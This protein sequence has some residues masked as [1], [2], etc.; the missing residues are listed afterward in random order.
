MYTVIQDNLQLFIVQKY[1][2]FRGFHTIEISGFSPPDLT[3]HNSQ[4][5]LPNQFKNRIQTTDTQSTKKEKYI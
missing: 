2:I 5:K 1:I 3:V 4:T